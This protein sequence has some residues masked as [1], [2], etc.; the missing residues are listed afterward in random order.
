MNGRSLYSQR[1]MRPS[2]MSERIKYATIAAM[3]KSMNA[4]NGRAMTC[5]GDM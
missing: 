2:G 3:K 5:Q 1:L 4:T